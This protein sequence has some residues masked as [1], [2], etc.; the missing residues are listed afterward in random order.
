MFFLSSYFIPTLID[1]KNRN[2]RLRGKLN[3]DNVKR[4]AQRATCVDDVPF[5]LAYLFIPYNINNNH[6]TLVVISFPENKIVYYDSFHNERPDI[7]THVDV[8]DYLR[9]HYQD[10]TG[11][12]DG[13]PE[14][15]IVMRPTG[16]EFTSHYSV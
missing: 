8:V 6:W 12:V 13:F 7:V 4:W 16:Y 10:T 1:E 11:S 9:L 2:C 14:W 5:K 3:Y 15:E